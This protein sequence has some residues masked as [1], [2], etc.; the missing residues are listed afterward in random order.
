MKKIAFVTLFLTVNILLLILLIHKQSAYVKRSYA[1]QRLEEQRTTLA[2]KKEQ[3]LQSLYA[4]QDAAHIKKFAHKELG[5]QPIALQQ[6]HTITIDNDC[7]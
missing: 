7:V 4:E 2:H 3:L 6:A 5:M 1:K